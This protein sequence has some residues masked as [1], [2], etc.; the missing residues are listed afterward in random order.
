MRRRE[1]GVALVVVMW[2]SI[3]LTV[4]ASSFIYEARTDALVVRN[5][6]SMARAEGIADAAVYRALFELYR[7]DNAPD[8]WRRDGTV[9][10]WSYEGVPVKV[11]IRDE[12]GKIDVNT[13]ADPLLRGLFQSV[14]MSTEDANNLLD[15]VLDWRDPD[16]LKRINGAEEPDYRAAGLTYRPANAPFQAIEEFQLVLGMRPDIY[17]KLAPFITTYSRQPGINPIL[18]ARE[19]LMAIPGVTPQIVDAY[20]ARRDQARAAGE[21][22]PPFPEAGGFT[23]NI[24]PTASIRA[25]ATLDDG[26]V[27]VR[28]AVALLR[29]TPRRPVTFVAWRESTAPTLGDDSADASNAAVAAARAASREREREE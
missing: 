27:F 20:I 1:R 14:G 25:E 21:P 18:A 4:I 29:P 15:A 19:V 12:S 10:D 9:R 24:T 28:E 22:P 7:A 5:T 17:K 13:A 16:N 8:A 23:A 6:I 26:T 11:E 3:L 2:V